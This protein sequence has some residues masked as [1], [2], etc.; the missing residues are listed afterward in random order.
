L[1]FFWPRLQCERH[2]LSNKGEDLESAIV[3]LTKSILLPPLS[4]LQ[5]GPVILSAL[6]HLARA[7]LLR[8]EVTKQP[9]D[10]ITATKFLFHLRDQPHEIPIIPRHQVTESLVETLTKQVEL[11]AGDMMQNIREI[12]ILSRE[13]LTVETSDIDTTRLIHFIWEV[14]SKIHIGVPEQPLDELIECLRAA[15]KRRPDLLEGHITLAK[16]LV[17]RYYMTG[18]DDDY[19][20]AASILDEIITSGNS[21]DNTVA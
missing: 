19:D 14:V 20:E 17:Y 16:C 3:H 10:V 9:E 1:F 5:Y 4:W 18:V 21:Q 7:L 13:L 11:G 8:S 15:M 12:A 6:F 2:A